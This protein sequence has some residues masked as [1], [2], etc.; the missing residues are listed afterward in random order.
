MYSN[1][2]TPKPQNNKECISLNNNL[3]MVE[4]NVGQY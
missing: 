2:T 1:K 3:I 4:N